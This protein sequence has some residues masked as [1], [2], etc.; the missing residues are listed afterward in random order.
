MAPLPPPPP[1]SASDP[2]MKTY[3]QSQELV[4][5]NSLAFLAKLYDAWFGNKRHHPSVPSVE[6]NKMVSAGV[7]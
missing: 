2:E 5:S 4:Q 7:G 1:G 6:D 3:H